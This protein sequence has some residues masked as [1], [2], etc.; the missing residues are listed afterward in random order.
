MVQR[1]ATYLTLQLQ[2][3]VT[4]AHE[5][6][7]AFSEEVIKENEIFELSK[8]QEMKELLQTYADGQVEL[9]QRVSLTGESKRL[10]SRADRL[11]DGRLG[12]DH[13]PAPAHTGRCVEVKVRFLAPDGRTSSCT[14][15]IIHDRDG[16]L[17][18]A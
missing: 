17:G 6:S 4:T 18:A 9:L 1:C 10:R 3:A 15:C 14:L 16:H 13:P 7:N 11:V 8:D 2:D 12:Q 5:T